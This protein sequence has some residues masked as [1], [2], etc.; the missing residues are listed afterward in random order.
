MCISTVLTMAGGV[1]EIAGFFLVTI[2]LYRL[3]RHEFGPLWFER[4]LAVSK[5]AVIRVWRKITRQTTTH[6][7]S[8][9]LEMSP[10]MGVA[11]A[12]LR[13]GTGGKT[14]EERVAALEAN[15]GALDRE[16]GEQRLE[17][18]KAIGQVQDK[19][20]DAFTELRQKQAQRE[21]EE[22]ALRRKSLKFQ[23]AGIPL[24]LL[25]V[26]FSV[27]GNIVGC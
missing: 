4:A 12:T 13:I 5:L 8:A 18:K 26:V 17:L 15:L 16:V 1:F 14:I 27:L 11:N 7:G 19:L 21:D 24:F 9:T 3:Q 6:Y 25:G 22:K 23:W 10:S 2:D 20:E